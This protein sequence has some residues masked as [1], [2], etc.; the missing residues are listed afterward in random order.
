MAEFDKLHKTLKPPELPERVDLP[1]LAVS[2]MIPRL[3]EPDYDSLQ[4]F[5]RGDMSMNTVATIQRTYAK[6]EPRQGG[7]S[8]QVKPPTTGLR[9]GWKGGK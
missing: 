2:D 4:Q 5:K 8:P 7:G 6:G 1:P 3:P 9:A